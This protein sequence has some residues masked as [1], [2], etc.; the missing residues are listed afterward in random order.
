VNPNHYPKDQ[1][2]SAVIDIPEPVFNAL[3]HYLDS[4]PAWTQGSIVIV[5]LCLFLMKNGETDSVIT[6][7]YL[8]T[9]Y[10]GQS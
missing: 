3:G 10:G 1:N 8:E 2:V 7:T 5:A 6:K 4:H 9:L